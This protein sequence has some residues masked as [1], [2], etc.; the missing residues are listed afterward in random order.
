AWFTDSGDDNIGFVTPYP[1][2]QPTYYPTPAQSTTR[3]I[4]L[5]PD[6]RIWITEYDAGKI[7]AFDPTQQKFTLEVSLQANAMPY[8]IVAGPDGALWFTEIGASAIGR[9]TV[10][11]KLTEY[12][13]LTSAASPTGITIG[14]DGALWFC[15]TGAIKIGRID[16][17]GNISEFNAP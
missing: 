7:A 1:S 17:K 8:E 4:A 3:G 11:G 2:C 6:N 14:P 10:K 12:S 5:G 16:T 15:E 13:P 9:V